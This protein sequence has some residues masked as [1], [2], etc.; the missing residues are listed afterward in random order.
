M[1]DLNIQDETSRLK[2]VVLGT[3]AV[4]DPGMLSEAVA[5]FGTEQVVAGI[6][7]RDGQVAVHGWQ[8]S[9][10]VTA[11]DLGR[12]MR[13][14][15]VARAVYTDIARD[16]MLTGVNVKATVGLARA[17]GLRIIASGGVA[18]LD[19]VRRLR[20]EEG[21]EGAIIGQALYTGQVS[22]AE[23]IRVAAGS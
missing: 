22:L 3:A 6:D 16:G 2:A 1:L 17:T 10:G 8:E 15:G 5:R 18:S 4:Q 13:R 23:A 20:V 9:S 12:D 19:D 7:A 14:R 21:I 11:V